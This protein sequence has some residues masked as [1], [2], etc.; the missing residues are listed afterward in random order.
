MDMPAEKEKCCEACGWPLTPEQVGLCD[1]CALELAKY[2]AE[3]SA[4]RFE[5]LAK[6]V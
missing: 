3:S 2:D 6:H 4:R 1:G 5:E